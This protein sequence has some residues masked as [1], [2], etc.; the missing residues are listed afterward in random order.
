MG[1]QQHGDGTFAIEP[2][3]QF[4]EA[5]LEFEIDPRGRFVKEKQFG[6]RFQRQGK[7]HTLL[8]AAGDLFEGAF[9]KAWRRTDLSEHVCEFL[10]QPSADT[11]KQRLFL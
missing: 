5:F 3:D 10:P 1:D 7:Q 8:L 11:E 9:Q 4:I 6:A 2:G